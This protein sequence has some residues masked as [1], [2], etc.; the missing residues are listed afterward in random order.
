M[1]FEPTASSMRPRRSSQLSYTPVGTGERSGDPAVAETDYALL[2]CQTDGN[3]L[4][5][6]WNARRQLTATGRRG[7]WAGRGRR[8]GAAAAWRRA[9]AGA[10]A[11]TFI[12]R[13]SASF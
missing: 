4:V 10:M 7:A 5:A 12:A 11:R 8:A 3:G 6:L 9:R 1:G 2:E 13:S